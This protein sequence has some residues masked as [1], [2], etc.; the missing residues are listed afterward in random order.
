MF[1]A[2]ISVEHVRFIKFRINFERISQEAK[3][4]DIL[5]QSIE[6]LKRRI[7]VRALLST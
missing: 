4:A 1:K 2:R 3:F 6:S 7:D 5:R